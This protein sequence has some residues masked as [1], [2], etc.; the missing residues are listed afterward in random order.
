MQAFATLW[1]REM[2]G[3]FLSLSGYVV[4]ATILLLLG[5]SFVDIVTKLS[6]TPTEA[7]ISEVFYQTLYFWLILLLTTPVITMRSFALEKFSGT[8]ETLMTVAVSDWQVVLAKFAGALTFYL[9]AWLPLV[10]YIAALQF[11]SGQHSLRL[12]P[13][14]ILTTFLGILLIGSLYISLGCLASALTKSQIVAAILSYGMGLALFILSLRS[15]MSD[16]ARG[17]WNAVLVHISM[18]EHMQ[19]F[20]RGIVDTRYLVFYGSASAVF[21][22]LTHRVVESRRWK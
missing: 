9:V 2:G 18:A 1:R 19:D 21:L 8:F 5:L 13:S 14:I 7:P 16:P 20:A 22:F 15:I 3:F 11:F 4:M 10:G 6:A 17:F 12:D